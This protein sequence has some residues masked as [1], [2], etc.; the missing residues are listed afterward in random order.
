MGRCRFKEYASRQ[1]QRIAELGHT[2]FSSSP[3]E[4]R[5]FTVDY[6]GK[7]AKVIRAANIKNRLGQS[8]QS[9]CRSGWQRWPLQLAIR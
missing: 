8:R 4:L 7:W 2:V 3:S 6:V 5:K 9:W 1:R